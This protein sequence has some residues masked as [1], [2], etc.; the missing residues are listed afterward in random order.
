VDHTGG[1]L[2]LQGGKKIDP[3]QRRQ[4]AATY[5]LRQ[6]DDELDF[7]D[8]AFAQ[9]DVVDGVHVA[10]RKRTALPVPSYPLTKL[11]QRGEGVEIEILA[12][13]KRCAQRFQ[14]A[15]VFHGFAPL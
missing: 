3:L 2:A 7:P 11:A 13:H 12:I 4:S 8:T 15:A 9:F 1:A 6:L 5:H 14:M 10:T